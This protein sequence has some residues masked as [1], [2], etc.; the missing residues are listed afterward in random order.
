M[1]FREEILNRVVV[2]DG[3]MGTMLYNRGVFINQCFD[4]L[5]ITNPALVEQ[6]HI[7]YRDAGVDV[8]ETNTYGANRFRLAPYGLREKLRELNLKGVEIA[9]KVAGDNMMVAGSVGPLGSPLEPLG[10]ISPAEAM[11]AFTEQIEILIEGGVDLILLET[12]PSLPEIELALQAARKITDLPILAQM[13]VD[14]DCNALFGTSPEV[15]ARRLQELGADAIGLNCKVGPASMLEAVERIAAV[16][17]LPISAQPNAGRARVVEGRHMFLCSPEYM[18]E[19]AKRFIQTG[20]RIIGGC[21][22]TT[23]AHMRA[24]VS[25]VRASSSG[26]ID[27]IS[28]RISVNEPHGTEALQQSEGKGLTERKPAGP[29]VWARKSAFAGKMAEGKFV[30]SVEITP[31]KGWKYT[32][33]LKGIEALRD[34]G[35]DAVNIPDSPRATAKMSC[36]AFAVIVQR[37]TGIETIM[38]YTCRDRNLLGMQ[39]DL[40]GA[41]ALGIKNV[42]AI[43]GD[44]PK[45][46]PYPFAT[47]VF[48]VDSI[49]LVSTVD[50]LNS[51]LDL[52][53]DSIG[54][55]TGF[56]VGV[57]ANPGAIDL[58]KEVERFEMKVRAG[59]EFAMTQPVF[60]PATLRVF[61]KRIQD[62]RI[63]VIAGVWPLISL[64]NAEFMNNEVPGAQVPDSLMERMRRAATAEEQRSVG[65][66]I[67]Q[68][69]INEIGDLVQGIQASVPLGKY[70]ST[71]EV[72]SVIPGFENG[73]RD[74]REKKASTAN[75]PK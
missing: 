6:I 64:R 66:R 5:N 4:E 24:V 39:S 58:D 19:Y 32:S 65:I 55:P 49:G 75:D 33:K 17:D 26:R 1:N 52:G 72:L 31:P 38:H 14:E 57:G 9:R 71:M 16:T 30:V 61:L 45:L 22:G 42:L 15:F 70:E 60:D 10:K 47:A 63:P 11:E 74:Y 73:F 20:V 59:A 36:L 46:G 27:N 12:F 7:E 23:P 37:E 35:V 41:Y 18:A 13:S 51:G 67:A 69:S 40:L 44:P 62:F 34:M 50:T 43:T 53:G 21:C 25:A 8:L 28:R 54:S 68:E 29:D 56:L 3:A 48:D 2:F